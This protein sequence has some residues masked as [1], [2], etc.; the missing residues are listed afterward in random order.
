MGCSVSHEKP[1]DS[2][3]KVDNKI[4]VHITPAFSHDIGGIIELKCDIPV[5]C[6]WRQNN[7]AALVNLSADRMKAT[8]VA[9]GEYE[10]YCSTYEHGTET[11]IVSA[12]VPKLQICVIDTYKITHASSDHARDGKIEAV[13]SNLEVNNTKY[14]WTSGIITDEPVL[15]D[16]QPGY[17][18]VTLISEDRFPIAFYHGCGIARVNVCENV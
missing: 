7:N 6:E 9:A 13:I 11:I 17:Y 18:A 1:N 8:N 5:N 12:K 2:Y 10:I 3:T 16:V 14:L 15:H 4:N